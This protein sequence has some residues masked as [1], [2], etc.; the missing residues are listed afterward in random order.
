MDAL[1]WALLALVIALVVGIYFFESARR[2]RRDEAA[3]E[4]MDA[5]DAAL[6]EGLSAEQGDDWVLGDDDLP[7]MSAGW[8]RAQKLAPEDMPSL[9][10]ERDPGDEPAVSSR[11]F[12]RAR[13]ESRV[14]NVDAA[15]REPAEELILVLN[16]MAEPGHQFTGPEIQEAMAEVDL[17]FGDMNVFHHYGPGE[18]RSSQALFSVANILEPGVF[19][20]EQMEALETPGLCMFMRLPGPVDGAVAFELMLNTG[21]RLAEHL[22]GELRDDTRSVLTQQNIGRMRERIAELAQ[23]RRAAQSPA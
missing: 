17:E 19:D 1:R 5:D 6:L 10:A 23:R 20:P 13:R 15:P 8:E 16:V 12:P 7:P 9:S 11:D 18:M 2:R 14:Y 22:G 3:A 21:Q 4:P